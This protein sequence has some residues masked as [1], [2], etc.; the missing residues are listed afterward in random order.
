MLLQRHKRTLSSFKSLELQHR[1]QRIHLALFCITK[2]STVGQ[3]IWSPSFQEGLTVGIDCIVNGC[4]VVWAIASIQLL[5][6]SNKPNQAAP[7]SFPL[8]TLGATAM[9]DSTWCKNKPNVSTTAQAPPLQPTA[10]VMKAW[11][12]LLV[13]RW[14]FIHLLFSWHFSR[15]KTEW[16]AKAETSTFNLHLIPG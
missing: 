6:S 16:G 1:N 3:N 8:T 4:N 7:R 11:K 14:P 9:W 10:N 15:W 2:Y 12:G 5:H 13:R